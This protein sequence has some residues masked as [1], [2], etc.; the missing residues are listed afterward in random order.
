MQ[1]IGLKSE[2]QEALGNLGMRTMVVAFHCLSKLPEI[3]NSL[4]AA[5]T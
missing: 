4:T 5:V 2:V 3:K 1:E